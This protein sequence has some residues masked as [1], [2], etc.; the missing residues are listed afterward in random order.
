VDNNNNIPDSFGLPEDYF[1]NSK[2]G[3]LNKIE[4]TQEHEAYPLLLALN[5]EHGFIAPNNY[6]NASAS[7]LELLSTPVLANVA[8][9]NSFGVPADYFTQNKLRIVSA[10]EGEYE[11]SAYPKLNTIEKVNP[12]ITSENYFETSKQTTLSK[13]TNQGGAKIISINRKPLWFAAAAVLTITI[14]LWIYNSFVKEQMIIDECTTLACLEKRDVIKYKLD[15]FD[16]EEI[17]DAAVDLDKLEKNL[18]KKEST[19][20]LKTTDSTDQ[21]LLDFID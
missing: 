3:I 17:L 8:K 21:A 2:A 16:T 14:G 20:S 18:N 5:K 10:I 4:W 9:Q 1:K 11:L 6:F 15:N 12:F 7:K 19:D 13:Y